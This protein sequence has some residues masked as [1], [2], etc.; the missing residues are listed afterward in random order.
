MTQ[1]LIIIALVSGQF[2][3]SHQK[4][5]DDLCLGTVVLEQRAIKRVSQFVSENSNHSRILGGCHTYKTDKKSTGDKTSKHNLNIL[6]IAN[7]NYESAVITFGNLTACEIAANNVKN[8]GQLLLNAQGDSGAL[9]AFCTT[10][11]E[12]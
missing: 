12:D 6:A 10:Q 1:I 11:K 5:K 4:I 2:N 7:S 9:D 8:S 3:I